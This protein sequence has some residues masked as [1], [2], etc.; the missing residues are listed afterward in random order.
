M[1]QP[2][3]T[4][5]GKVVAKVALNIDYGIIDHF[6]NHLY[7][8]PNKAIEELVANGFDA[9]ATWVRVFLPNEYTPK[10]VVVWG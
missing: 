3:G 7:G 5:V 8:S 1:E 9:F 2:L 4:S 10:N 6:S